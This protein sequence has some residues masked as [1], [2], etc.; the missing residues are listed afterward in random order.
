MSKDKVQEVFYVKTK[1]GTVFAIYD[2]TI[3]DDCDKIS[4]GY[5][6]VEENDLDKSHYDGEIKVIVDQMVTKAIQVEIADAEKRENT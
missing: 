6:F 1:D 4:F 2:L 5:N 3:N